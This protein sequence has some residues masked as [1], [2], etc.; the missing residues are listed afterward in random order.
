[1]L[2]IYRGVGAGGQGGQQ[3]PQYFVW[4]ALPPQYYGH[5]DTVATLQF[6]SMVLHVCNKYG[7]IL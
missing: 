1:M 2:Y 6:L 7:T 4:G 5:V 3:P